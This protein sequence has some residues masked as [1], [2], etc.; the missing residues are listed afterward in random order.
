M[1]AAYVSLPSIVAWF[2]A[3]VVMNA[4][5]AGITVVARRV[6]RGAGIAQDA[7]MASW[8]GVVGSLCA[9]MLAFAII[10]LWNG[11]RAAQTNVDTEA[12][13][14]RALL[15]EVLPSVRPLVRAY[16]SAVIEEW[17]SLCG[18][19]ESQKAKAALLRLESESAAA[20]PGF[21]SDLSRDLQTLETLRYERL[22]AAHSMVP[23]E[24]WA[25][26]FLIV[27]LVV[28]LLALVPIEPAHYH[29]TLMLILATALGTVMWAASVLD[30]P[31]CGSYALRPDA[32]T[33][34]VGLPMR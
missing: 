1:V 12:S 5:A 23:P 34:I 29:F 26:L 17:P 8:I 25:A 24:L 28:C 31:Y 19:G 27:L 14:T 10:N 22:R 33:Q 3:I 7:P 11:E 4:I 30:F 15:R 20:R 32:L 13:L 6:V 16:L 18:V 9:V 21:V 2:L